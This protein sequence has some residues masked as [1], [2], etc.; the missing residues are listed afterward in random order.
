MHVT[1]EHFSQC[2]GIK[3]AQFSPLNGSRLAATAVNAV[4]LL[5]CDTGAL[6]RTLE[7]QYR[8]LVDLGSLPQKKTHTIT[9]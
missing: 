4:T 2:R 1:L 5:D 8:S 3:L 7:R 9:L 6:L